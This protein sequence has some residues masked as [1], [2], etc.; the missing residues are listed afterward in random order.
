MCWPG[1][2]T[3]DPVRWLQ[4]L[5]TIKLSCKKKK[6]VL[7]CNFTRFMQGFY[8]VDKETL[9][10]SMRGGYTDP[11]GRKMPLC[12]TTKKRLRNGPSNVTKSLRRPPGLSAPDPNPIVLHRTQLIKECVGTL[13]SGWNQH[14][15]PN[16]SVFVMLWLIVIARLTITVIWCRLL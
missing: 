8:A 4:V 1:H 2:G 5:E 10:I 3:K 16:R 6:K 9:Y 15:L 14:H 13:C 12:R 11:T 7:V